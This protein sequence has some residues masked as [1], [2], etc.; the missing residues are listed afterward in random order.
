MILKVLV[1]AQRVMLFKVTSLP[2]ND[3]PIKMGKK[4]DSL[5]LCVGKGPDT[6]GE[7]K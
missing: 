6:I 4:P 1:M 7:E 5:L 3:H 2:E